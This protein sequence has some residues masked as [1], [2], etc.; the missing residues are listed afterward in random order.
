MK[1]MPINAGDFSNTMA[2]PLVGARLLE[3]FASSP[4]NF[5][6]AYRNAEIH[7]VNDEV[8]AKID[9]LLL[10]SEWAMAVEVAYHIASAPNGKMDVVDR[11][12]RRMEQIRKRP[13][14]Q[15]VGKK[16]LGAIAGGII[17]ADMC[18]KAHEAGFFAIG[19]RRFSTLAPPPEGFVPKEW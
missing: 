2:K 16:L 13:L 19:I 3:R 7:D 5:R 1:K 4:Y 6:Y 12:V 14:A 18:K 15:I 8:C 10:G 11:H 9:I 17:E